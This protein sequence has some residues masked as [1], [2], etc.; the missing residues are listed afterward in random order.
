MRVESLLLNSPSFFNIAEA[1][2]VGEAR[3]AAKA[4]ASSLGFT[5][6]KQGELALIVTEIATNIVHHATQGEL[7]LRGMESDGVIG[8]EV[9]ALDKGPGMASVNQCLQDGFSTAGTAGNGLGAIARLSAHFDVYSQ[10]GEGTVL[11]SRIWALSSPFQHSPTPMTYGVINRP[12][13]GQEVCGD[14]WAVEHFRDRSLFFLADGL[15]HGPD[16]FLASQEAVR[17]FRRHATRRPKELLEAVHAAIHGTRG[18][19]A[20]LAEVNHETQAVTFTGVGNIAGTIVTPPHS[21]SMVSHNGIVGHQVRKVQE[22]VY[23]WSAGALLVMH[24]D[25]LSYRWQ[26]ERYAGLT[27]RNPSLI[28]GILYRD[29]QRTND[30]ATVLVARVAP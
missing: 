9:I 13:P 6:T 15:G 21:Q 23:P 20:G 4:L 24:S 3:R 5:E 26:L 27:V 14:S 30:D 25:G 17:A 7:H 11:L 16:A 29:F 28:A 19:A 10:P 18:V 2:Q 8:V 12:K 22:F 1:S